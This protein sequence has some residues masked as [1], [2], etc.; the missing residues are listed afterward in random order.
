MSMAASN[1]LLKLDMDRMEFST[2]NLPPGNNGREVVIVEPGEGKLGMFSLTRDGRDVH[3]FTSMKSKAE[4]IEASE[5]LVENT[6]PLPCNC[7]IVGAFEGYIFLQG[8]ETHQ[9]RV[10]AACYSLEIKTLKI[11]RVNSINYLY[12]HIHP[13]FGYP[14]FMSP[15]MIEMD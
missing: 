4:E 13:Y 12:V 7:N 15:R 14:P 1:K 10:E 8:V 3:Y 9:G 6:I 5:W 2:V 11:E